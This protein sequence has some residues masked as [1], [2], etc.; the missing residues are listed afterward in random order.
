MQ[1]VSMK[2]PHKKHNILTKNELNSNVTNLDCNIFTT[3]TDKHLEVRQSIF[4]TVIF[5]D[6]SDSILAEQPTLR[7]LTNSYELSLQLAAGN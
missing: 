3:P 6:G 5:H 2:L 4:C 7:S 1:I